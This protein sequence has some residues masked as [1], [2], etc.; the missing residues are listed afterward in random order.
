MAVAVARGSSLNGS[1]KLLFCTG[2]FIHFSTSL[3]RTI[4]ALS[5]IERAREASNGEC[6]DIWEC[7]DIAGEPGDDDMVPD[8]ILVGGLQPN[9]KMCGAKIG[10]LDRSAC[11]FLSCNVKLTANWKSRWSLKGGGISS[12]IPGSESSSMSG[13]QVEAALLKDEIMVRSKTRRDQRLGSGD[14]ESVHDRLNRVSPPKKCHNFRV[15]WAMTFW[16]SDR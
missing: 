2:S 8:T 6:A 3:F 14:L 13:Q 4:G 9:A 1:V 12:E 10:D 7:V 5:A 15:L 16:V 11:R